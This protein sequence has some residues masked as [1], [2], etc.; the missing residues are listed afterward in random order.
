MS[1]EDIGEGKIMP[2]AH[3][4]SKTQTHLPIGIP[5]GR[6]ANERQSVMGD[7][8]QRTSTGGHCRFSRLLR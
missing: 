6:Q 1:W 7:E 2:D 5:A 8:P 3:E 4:G